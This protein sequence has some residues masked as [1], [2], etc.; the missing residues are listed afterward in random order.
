MKSVLIANRGE[1]ACRIFR[2][3]EALGLEKLAVYSDADAEGQH[4]RMADRAVRIGEG[5]P[6]ASYLNTAAVLDAAEALGADAIHPGYGFLS[7]NVEFAAAV[8]KAGHIWIGPGIHA[9]E[10]MSQKVRAREL[11]RAAGVPVVPGSEALGEIDDALRRAASM[12]Y[13][14]MVKAASGGGGIGMSIAHT[15]DDLTAAL[16][17][18]RSRAQRFFAGDAVY[19][20]KY[21]SRARHVEVQVLG[22]NSGAIAVVGDRDCSVQRRHQKVLEE[23]PCSIL[24]SDERTRLYEIARAAAAQVQYRGAGTIEMILDLDSRDF[25]FL[26]MNTRLQVEHPVTELVSGLDLVEAQIRI[27]AG[28]DLDQDLLEQAGRG[29]AIEFRVYAEDPVRFLP[30]PG[31]ISRWDPPTGPHLRIDSG[32]ARGDTVSTFY[33]PLMAKLCVHAPDRVTAL[34]QLTAAASAFKIEGPKNNLDLVRRLVDQ[35]QFAANDH[36][37]N[38]LGQIS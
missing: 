19:L 12:G 13:P 37:T 34:E 33:D 5:P 14:V 1:I 36:D 38:L 6:T 4:V 30:G 21:I 24:T 27:A 31:R 20:E 16:E 9:M 28:E 25:Y 22:L 35:P 32:Y 8:L 18:T 7:E 26:E 29:H 3:C 2:T 15:P 23:A 17:T 11:M 10:A